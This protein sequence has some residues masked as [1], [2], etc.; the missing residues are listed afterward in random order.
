MASLSP[1]ASAQTPIAITASIRGDIDKVDYR[2]KLEQTQIHNHDF[3]MLSVFP[4]IPAHPVPITYNASMSCMR[5]A[6]SAA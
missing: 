4:H 2:L 1:C 3:S 6:E 5:C